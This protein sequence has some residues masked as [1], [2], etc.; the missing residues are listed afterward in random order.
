MRA[1]GLGKLFI[2]KKNEKIKLQKSRFQM[3]RESRSKVENLFEINSLFFYSF[4]SQGPKET[5]NQSFMV[6]N[7]GKFDIFF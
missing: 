5:Q 7:A 1:R 3:L 2:F 4:M 6:K